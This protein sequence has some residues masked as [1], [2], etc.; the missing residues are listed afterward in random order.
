VKGTLIIV[1]LCAAI[2]AAVFVAMIVSIS[3]FRTPIRD[4]RWTSVVS[5]ATEILWALVPIAIVLATAMPAL[6]AIVF[7]AERGSR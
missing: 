2:V 6:R 1:W 7:V 4:C 5:K 3:M